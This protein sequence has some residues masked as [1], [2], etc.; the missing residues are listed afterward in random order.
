MMKQE[1]P[2]TVLKAIREVLEGRLYLSNGIKSHL[3][4]EMMEKAG[5]KRTARTGLQKLSD[6]ELEVYER[7]G[8]GQTTR[9]IADA[10]GI[11]VKTV[12]THRDHI[13]RKLGMRN[14]AELMRHAVRWAEGQTRLER[15]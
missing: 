5:G 4:Q 15:D 8:A 14:S 10:L 1:P 9:E 6:R 2:E 11:S 13:R 7:F 12:E 3:L